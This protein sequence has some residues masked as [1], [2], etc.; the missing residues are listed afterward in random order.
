MTLRGAPVGKTPVKV[1]ATSAPMST[2]AHHPGHR[3]AKKSPGSSLRAKWRGIVEGAPGARFQ[4][5]HARAQRQRGST[6]WWQRAAQLVLAAIA[7]ALGLIFAVLPGPAVLFFAIAGA[8]VATESRTVAVTLDRLE[9]RL[10][11]I[12]KWAGGHWHRLRLPGR[13]AVAATGAMGA[14]GAA[15]FTGWFLFWR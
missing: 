7:F 6:P 9:L 15:A 11:A 14:L 12:G 5:A 13:I 4:H 3:S 8:L 2:I 1:G 10:R